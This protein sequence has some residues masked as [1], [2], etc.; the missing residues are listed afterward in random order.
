[1]TPEDAGRR[2]SRAARWVAFGTTLV[3]GVYV[4]LRLRSVPPVWRATSRMIS[5][6]AVVAWYVLTY[7]IVKRV[8]LE[9]LK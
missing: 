2:A 9:W 4:A 8:A 7:R 1:M 5:A 6:L 3:V